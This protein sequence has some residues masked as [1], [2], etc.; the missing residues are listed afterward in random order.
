MKKGAIFVGLILFSFVLIG[1][2]GVVSGEEDVPTIIPSN[3]D[4]SNYVTE[5]I[6]C[7]FNNPSGIEM[8]F[9]YFNSNPVRF[10]QDG[11]PYEKSQYS[12]EGE[13]SCSITINQK[14]GSI[15]KWI[16]HEK[17]D[18]TS[19]ENFFGFR[20]TTIIDGVDENVEFDCKRQ[21]PIASLLDILKDFYYNLFSEDK[22]GYRNLYYL[23]SDGTEEVIL[24]DECKPLSEGRVYV[25]VACKEKMGM[26]SSGFDNCLV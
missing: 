22:I 23:C 26:D 12:C 21:R 5:T 13:D 17:C 2:F 19:E 1:S 16:A 9:S 18:T 7:K 3:P 24:G 15:I 6:T 25:D 20:E 8:C 4:T 10:Y 14:N 11:L